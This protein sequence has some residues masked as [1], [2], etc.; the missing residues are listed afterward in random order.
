MD[1]AS[2]GL[3]EHIVKAVNDAGYTDP[4]PVQLA[5]IPAALAG[6]DLVVSSQTG[7]GKTAAFMLPSLQRLTTEPTIKARGPRVLV[8]TPTRELAVQVTDAC[9]GY[10]KNLRTPRPSASSAACPTRCR[11]SCCPAPTKSW[12]PPRPPDGPDEQRPHR[13]RPPRNPDPRRSRPHARHGLRGRHRAIVAKLP[14]N[15]QTLFFSATLDGQV[16]RMMQRLLKDPE[17]IEINS[18]Q[19][20]HENIEQRLLVADDIG[21]KNRLLDGILRD[22]GVEQ[23]IVFTA[24]KRDADAL[25]LNLESQGHSVAALHGDMNQRMRTRTLDQLRR[26]HLRVLIATDVAA[27]GIDVRTISHVINYDLPK[28]AADYVHRIG[29]TGRGGSSGIAISLAERRD[30]RL[31]RAIE[32][33]TRQPL[34]VHT[35]PGLEARSTMPADDRRPGGPRRDGGRSFGNGGGRFGDKRPSSGQRWQPLRPRTP[36]QLRRCRRADAAPW[37]SRP[38]SPWAGRSEAVVISPRSAPASSPSARVT[39]STAP[40]SPTWPS[41]ARPTTTPAAA[42]AAAAAKAPAASPAPAAP[43]TATADRRPA[44]TAQRRLGRPF[45]VA[46]RPTGNSRE[47]P[48][49]SRGEAAA[50]AYHG[51]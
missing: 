39:R 44:A 7:S 11:T 21:H 50:T 41:A 27:R 31:L 46:R 5:A 43:S 2:L 16:A 18:A 45:S 17:R 23:A 9:K 3:S 4:D 51:S 30:V 13:L 24:T 1:F 29:R 20:R 34:A 28:V 40:S 36:P 12:W 42:S 37:R 14:A 6:K 48:F 25:T 15:R 32:R 26:G 49:T 19:T 35:L 22:V 33:Y 10:G 47:R 38:A 8:L